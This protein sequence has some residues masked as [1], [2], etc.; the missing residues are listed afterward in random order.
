M[1]KAIKILS[2]FCG[3]LLAFSCQNPYSIFSETTVKGVY[4]YIVGNPSSTLFYYNQPTS[5][6]HAKMALSGPQPAKQLDVF[7]VVAGVETHVK[8]IT[9]PDTTYSVTLNDVATAL[10]QPVANFTPGK[11]VVLRNKLTATDGTLWSKNNTE[12]AA[13]GLLS[14][15]V[16]QNLFQDLVVFVTCPF[17][18][19]D[20]AGNYHVVQDDWQD[21][22]PGDPLTVSVVDANNIIIN[23]YP[24][25]YGNNHHG[26]VITV[27]PNSGVATVTKQLSGGYSTSDTEYT[28]GSG[29]V[30]SCVGYIKLVLNFT[31]N[32]GAYNGNTLI[33]SK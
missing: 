26:L 25:T 5:A 29:Y 1:K 13:G 30:F 10:N 24:A 15:T 28:A 7:V 33:I 27:D 8:T 19:T 14:G 11:Q 2:L 12:T 20:A 3:I 9:L 23:E 22:N 32:G 21:Y 18:A 4:P 17:V 16:Y 6:F 31:Y